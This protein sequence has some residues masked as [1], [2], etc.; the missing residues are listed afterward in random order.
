MSKKTIEGVYY[1][2]AD[3]GYHKH[4]NAQI[5]CKQQ[6]PLEKTSELSIIN[7]QINHPSPS[8][9]ATEK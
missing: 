5:T 9:R 8:E 7:E 1:E 4:K 3:N 2:L 6:Q